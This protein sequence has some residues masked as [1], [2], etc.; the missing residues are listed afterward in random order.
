MVHE[1]SS[2]G[3][4]S[5]ILAMGGAVLVLVWKPVGVYKNLQELYL[6]DTSSPSELGR[7]QGCHEKRNL[8]PSAIYFNSLDIR[9]LARVLVVPNY[10]RCGLRCE[11]RGAGLW[12]GHSP[13]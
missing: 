1:F 7:W 6:R 10:S 2:L 3:G 4:G 13:G 5:S 11:F 8:Q 9:A 12:N